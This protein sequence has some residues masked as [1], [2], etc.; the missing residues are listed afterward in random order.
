MGGIRRH[1]V[2]WDPHWSTYVDRCVAIERSVLCNSGFGS[3]GN[4]HHLVHHFVHP[5]RMHVAR[6]LPAITCIELDREAEK[7]ILNDYDFLRDQY[8]QP[9]LKQPL[10]F[11]DESSFTSRSS[12]G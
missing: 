2:R 6:N 12:S 10:L 4:H 5:A 7:S 1:D 3:A 11:P 8:L 9:A